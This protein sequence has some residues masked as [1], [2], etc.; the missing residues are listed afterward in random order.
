MQRD[1]IL[2]E[3][4]IPFSILILLMRLRYGDEKVRLRMIN[5]FVY[6][7]IWAINLEEVT[8]DKNKEPIACH[9]L[10]CIYQEFSKV[11]DLNEK[12]HHCFN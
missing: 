8:R 10:E 9:L 6:F 3:N 12:P 11:G 5:P 7:I 2:L 1:M 4:Q